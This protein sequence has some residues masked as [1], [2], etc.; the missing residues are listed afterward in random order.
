MALLMAM[1]LAPQPV[2]GAF[3]VA[4]HGRDNWSGTLSAPNPAG[5][6][7][8]FQSPAAAVRAMRRPGAARVVYLRGGSYTL[9]APLR[10]GP[11]DAG[12]QILA[13]PG[14]QPVLLG[15]LPLTGWRDAGS[16]GVATSAPRIIQGAGLPTV[17]RDG[18]RVALGRLPADAE[19][20]ASAASWFFADRP[21]A[22]LDTHRGF[23]VREGDL[24]L[25]AAIR[26]GT[27]V[28]IFGQRGW[29]NYVAPVKSADPKT[30][31]VQ[32]D[33]TTWGALG[34]GSRFALL[35][36]AGQPGTW[37]LDRT[38]GL[39]R[40]RGPAPAEP[41]VAA[42][43]LCIL[44][45]ENTR[46]LTVAHLRLVGSAI[47]GAG[48][49]LSHTAK[50]TLRGLGIAQTGDGI[51]L[52]TARNTIIEGGEI[53]DTGGFGIALRH[54]SDGTVVEQVWLHDIGWLRADA[55]AIWFD[56]S[57]HNRFAQ[58]RIE[59][60]SKFGIGGGALVDGGAY[61]NRIE[62]NE[63]DRANLR[64]S[65]GGGIMVIGWAQDATR[66]VIAGN[67]IS[68]TTA[69]GNIGWDNVPHTT[70]QDPVTR[71]VSYAI[72][73]DDWASDVMVRGNLL[74]RNVG[75]IDLHAGWND[76]VAENVLIGN[77]GVALV[78]DAQMW[79]GAGAHP[80]AMS[81]NVFERNTVALGSAPNGQ[82]GI[83]TL[84]GPTAAAL[85]RN[86]R[87]LGRGLEDGAFH[88]ATEHSWQPYSFGFS[89]W[90]DRGED[91][92]S[93]IAA[94]ADGLVLREGA[95]RLLAEAGQVD[96]LALPPSGRM[97]DRGGLA[98]RVRQRCG[99]E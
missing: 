24:A 58:N 96:V 62:Y 44:S 95:L 5:T 64:T 99:L 68:H 40:L 98:E 80:H 82:S 94:S 52:D 78:A 51:R 60:I 9:A 46:D 90:Q 23:R 57:S 86:N 6:D 76:T 31:V 42:N 29:Q 39:L 25:F 27:M 36:V 93:R 75:G 55:S 26:P 22:G 28:S 2:Q 89:G 72:Y 37:W 54:R 67:F 73:L 3:F 15:G 8:P 74:C 13:Y 87:Y 77:S 19:R 41:L 20:P 85:F 7:G 35:N 70:F 56:G 91:M 84:N 69:L 30:R 48:V 97:V 92:G 66:D 83:A 38:A 63:I 14:E 79:L 45:L 4:P 10:L 34:E 81:D 71:L 18:R 12:D 49:C 53:A 43:L 11:E 61:D 50:V 88:Q 32:L 21:P 1:P 16:D 59:N 65:D 33:G 17:L 47:D